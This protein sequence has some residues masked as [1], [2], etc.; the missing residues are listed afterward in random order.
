MSEF[1]K[2]MHLNRLSLGGVTNTYL[3]L[4]S[5]FGFW[6]NIRGRVTPVF[7]VSTEMSKGTRDNEQTLYL[8]CG[9]YTLLGKYFETNNKTPVVMQRGGQHV[10]TITELLLKT[11][12]CNLLLGSCNSLT[13]TME[14]GLFYMW[15]VRR[16]YLARQLGRP[17]QF[18]RV[19]SW[20][21]ASEENIRRLVWNGRQPG[22]QLVD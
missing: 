5:N 8:Y 18:S 7:I 20:K 4:F 9:V 11:V 12:L 3:M 6:V 10:P 15:F 21:S 22:T 13:T 14:T 16:S 17:S 2:Y 19:V 1:P